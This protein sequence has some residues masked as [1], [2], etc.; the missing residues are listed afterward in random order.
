MLDAAALPIVQIGSSALSLR[1][2]LP[3]PLVA[4]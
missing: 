4:E 3:S 1:R 2:L